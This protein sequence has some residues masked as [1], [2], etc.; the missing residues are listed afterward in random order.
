MYLYNRNCIID[1]TAI[2]CVCVEQQRYTTSWL[3][4]YLP[5]IHAKF[6][7]FFHKHVDAVL[8]AT[9]VRTYDTPKLV[10]FSRIEIEIES[11]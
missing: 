8:K 10:V 9:A 1:F 6:K 4:A 5:I 2:H 11:R 3:Y 7:V